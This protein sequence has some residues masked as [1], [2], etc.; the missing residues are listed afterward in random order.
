MTKRL[1]ERFERAL[2][3][4]PATYIDTRRESN[5]EDGRGDR[6]NVRVR[7]RCVGNF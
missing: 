2:R 3:A 7:N 1:S 4:I 6:V 5:S